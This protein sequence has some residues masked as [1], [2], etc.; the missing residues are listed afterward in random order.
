MAASDTN[1]KRKE[2]NHD[3]G[4]QE[5]IGKNKTKRTSMKQELL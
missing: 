2:E 3:S 4:Q 5:K 1:V